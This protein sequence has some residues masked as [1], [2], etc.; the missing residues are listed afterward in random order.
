VIEEILGRRA[1]SFDDFAARNAAIFR[2]E[3]AAPKV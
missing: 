1:T 3:Q 2:G